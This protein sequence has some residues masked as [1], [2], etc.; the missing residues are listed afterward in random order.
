LLHDPHKSKEANREA[1]SLGASTSVWP[2][3]DAFESIRG[4][5]L[6]IEFENGKAWARRV[7]PMKTGQSTLTLMEVMKKYDKLRVEDY[8]RTYSWSPA[9]ITDLWTDVIDTAAEANTDHFFGTL[10]LQLNP[11]EPKVATIVDGQQRLTTVFILLSAIRDAVS[12]LTV[13]EIAPQKNMLAPIRPMEIAW[14][15]ILGPKQQKGE[16]RFE[17]SRFL[18]KIMSE[19]V[20]AEPLDQKAL[21]SRDKK[22]TI[23]LRKGVRHARI[24]VQ[25][26]LQK[27]SNDQEKLLKAHELLKSLT[28]KFYVLQIET[29]SIGESLDIFL[30][31]NNRGMP[32]GPSDL[33]RGEL[34]RILG[35]G[36]DEIEQGKLQE[37][38]LDE[39]TEIVE[40]VA[41]PEV[42]LRH[43]LLSTGGDKVQKKLVVDFVKKRL[44]GSDGEAN[45]VQEAE[46]FWKGLKEAATK[47][48]AFLQPHQLGDSA[49]YFVELLEGLQKSHRIAIL[50]LL[51]SNYPE[52]VRNEIIRLI[53]VLSFRWSIANLNRQAIEDLFQDVSTKIRTGTPH[54]ELVSELE[55]RCSDID[56]DFNKFFK[57]DI[58]DDF[59]TRAALHFINKL[60][61]KGVIIHD[62]KSLHLEHIAPQTETDEWLQ[63]LFGAD[64]KAYANYEV[65]V[66]RGGNLTLLDPGLNT[67]IGNK[68]FSD[69]KVEYTK[70]GLFITSNLCEFQNWD[71]SLITERG[72][73]LA[74]SFKQ[75]CSAAKP[76]KKLESFT[77]WYRNK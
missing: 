69:K 6:G 51:L 22:V 61:A 33:V 60:T 29:G 54:S 53:Y 16:F 3:L 49:S 11:G 12:E 40:L 63:A 36:L 23:A 46:K 30:T 19:C 48:G 68:S 74:D 65:A 2:V 18:R 57:G 37:K 24:L 10:I 14:Q 41:E 56:V 58:D 43:Y 21:P 76:P 64:E 73:W 7:N 1:F 15:T 72:E 75:L 71:D 9:Q 13:Q 38:I 47:Y 27:N 34:M 59:V 8:Q 26:E 70:S 55:Q 31:L 77:D 17:S 35:N 45:K 32:L 25:K 5:P 44:A 62:L 52:E 4:R 39:W 42:F 50:S 67:K 66:T 20:L 28:D